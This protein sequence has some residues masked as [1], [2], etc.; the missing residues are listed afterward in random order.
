ML[1][2]FPCLQAGVKLAVCR[3]IRYIP[4]SYIYSHFFTS[5]FIPGIRGCR[6]LFDYPMNTS[7]ATRQALIA[8]LVPTVP[9]ELTYH[10]L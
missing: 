3:G 5:S 9:L 8:P 7:G 10:V 2:Q 1:R 6:G 4:L